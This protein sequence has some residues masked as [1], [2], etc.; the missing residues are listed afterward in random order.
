M[1][2]PRMTTSQGLCNQKPGEGTNGSIYNAGELG[3]CPN[4]LKGTCGMPL[5]IHLPLLQVP[6][7][8]F[9]LP[10][11]VRHGIGQKKEVEQGLLS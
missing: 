7:P 3:A 8:E 10:G 11:A 5:L 1:C 4:S 2:C 6:P 9:C